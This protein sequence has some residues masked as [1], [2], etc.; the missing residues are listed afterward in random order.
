MTG[1]IAPIRIR[2]TSSRLAK[3]LIAIPQR[4]FDLFPADDSGINLQFDRGGPITAVIYRPYD[5]S[6]HEARIYGL[7]EWFSRSGVKKGD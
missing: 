4:Y 2:A 3:G 7:R 1:G 6:A 5:S